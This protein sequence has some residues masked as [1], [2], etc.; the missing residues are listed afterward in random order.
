MTGQHSPV[1]HRLLTAVLTIVVPLLFAAGAVIWVLSFAAELPD[2]VAVHWGADGRPDGF[3]PWQSAIGMMILIALLMCGLAAI[4]GIR[5]GRAAATR[6]LAVFLGLWSGIALPWFIAGTLHLQRGLADARQAP[7]VNPALW[8]SFAGAALIAAVGALLVP[9]DARMPAADAVPADAI[10]LQLSDSEAASWR[11]SVE[12]PGFHWI[13]GIGGVATVVLAVLGLWRGMLWADLWA[14]TV[15]FLTVLLVALGRWRVVVDHTGL[16]VS[17][18]ISRPRTHVPLDEVVEAEVGSISPLGDFGGW[19]YRVGREG[20]VGIVVRSGEA[21][22]V[23]RTGGRN[24][25]ITVDDAATG[26]A[27]LNTLADRARRR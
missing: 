13:A 18:L 7:D 16:T 14:G 4:I 3:G 11:R 25:A 21:L 22:T 10:R 15:G 24:L 12:I 20:T 27:L 1:P 19:G 9:G 6:R 2:P 23:Q 17:P 26:A 5:S 8:V